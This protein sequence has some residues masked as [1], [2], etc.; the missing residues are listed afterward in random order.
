MQR[1]VLTAA[2]K[3]Y[4]Y[5]CA[6]GLPSVYL[7]DVPFKGEDGRATFPAEVAE[8]LNWEPLLAAA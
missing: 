4:A 5:A 1:S 6:P 7:D 8:V 3:M 2:R